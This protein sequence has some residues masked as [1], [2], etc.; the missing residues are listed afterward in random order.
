MNPQLQKLRRLETAMADLAH[1]AALIPSKQATLDPVQ[2]AEQV[3]GYRLDTWQ[4][5]VLGSYHKRELLLCSRQVGKTETVALKAAYMARTQPG[6]RILTLA[7]SHRQSRNL[8]SRISHT[9]AADPNV[10]L[11][12]MTQTECDLAGNGSTIRALPGNDPDRIRGMVADVILID[13]GAFVLDSVLQIVFPMISTTNG[14][15]TMLSTPSGPDGVFYEEWESGNGWNRTRALAEDCPRISAE[16]LGEARQRLGDLAYRQEY[17]CEFI[18][19]GS[20]FFSA[21]LIADAFADPE[22]LSLIQEAFN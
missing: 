5:E 21:D 22:P 19:S 12:R 14:S 11:D 10:S 16:F 1:K 8:F 18:Q 9:L 20:A 3:T 15:I 13:E 17:G 7:P 6:C 4:K 2:W